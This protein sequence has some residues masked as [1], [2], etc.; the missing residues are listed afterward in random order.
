MRSD[1]SW[2]RL[3]REALVWR[4][5][6][7]PNVLP[8]FGLSTNAFPED[9]LPALLSPWMEY[10]SLKEYILRADYKPEQEIPRLV[11]IR[12]AYAL[13]YDLTIQGRS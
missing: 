5:L 13:C 7:H 6:C 11:R 12:I 3:C 9:T 1:V 8:F 2:K 4:Q 10:G